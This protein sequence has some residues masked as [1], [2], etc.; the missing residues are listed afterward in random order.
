MP[1]QGGASGTLLRRCVHGASVD[2]PVIWYEGAG[3]GQRRSLLADHL[4]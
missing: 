4:A 2:D 1:A 3:L